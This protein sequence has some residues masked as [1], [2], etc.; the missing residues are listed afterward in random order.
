MQHQKTQEENEKQALE[1]LDKKKQWFRLFQKKQTPDNAKRQGKERLSHRRLLR[2]YLDLS[3]FERV[4]ETR[5]MK[6]LFN[7]VVFI[8]V[9]ITLALLALAII[10]KPGIL[11]PTMLIIG[12][13][14]GVFGLLLVVSFFSL[15]FFLDV[16][17]FNR[18]LQVEAVLPDFLQLTSA[19]ISAGMPIDKAF[20]YAVRPQFGILAKEIEEVAKATIAG[21][22]LGKALDKFASKYD[23]PMLKR[24]VNLIL[25]GI[26]A[27]GEMADLL[28]KI[29]IN[30]QE[31][32]LM[33]RE[34]AANVTTYVI[35]IGFATIAG[36]PMLFALSTTL[37]GII[38]N[39]VSGI[40]L[41]STSQS[42][43]ISL[44]FNANAVDISNFKLFSVFALI[45]TSFFSA[46]IISIIR[47]GN[48]KEGM[49]YIPIF[50]V[51]TIIL[52]FFGLWVLDS[53]FSGMF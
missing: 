10:Y 9:A 13:W 52:Y 7:A 34:M 49:K 27:G 11:G 33:K 44:T 46:S 47:K 50:M 2:K 30:I 40:D 32:R 43:G 39:V 31:L 51:V 15:F 29:A 14:T 5:L 38:Q 22:D 28:N 8:C 23:S 21:E 16:R 35:F 18:K 45:V 20:W 37:A 24:S 36:A 12:L 19:N 6:R 3:G 48:I 25:E 53:L 42:T 26:Q 4:D 1:K 17:M 41:G